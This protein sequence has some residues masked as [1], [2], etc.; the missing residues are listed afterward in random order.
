ML[1]IVKW[2][3]WRILAHLYLKV[4]MVL[5]CL[6]KSPI[7]GKSSIGAGQVSIYFLIMSLELLDGREEAAT[8]IKIQY[9]SNPINGLRKL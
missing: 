7:S 3:I 4:V 9:K 8:I 1:L 6:L 2:V 5:V